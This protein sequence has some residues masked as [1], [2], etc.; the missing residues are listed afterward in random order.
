MNPTYTL[1]AG[2]RRANR[3]ATVAVTGAV[4]LALIPLVWLLVTVVSRGF[5]RLDAQFFTWS[6]R[7]VVGEGGGA[8][9]AIVGTVLITAATTAICVPI[10]VGTAIYLVEYGRGW[11]PRVIRFVVVVLTG[12]PSIVAGLFV[13]AVI[14]AICGPGTRSG[15]AGAAALSLLMIP[16]VITSS[17]EILALVPNRLREAAIGLGATKHRIITTVI[18][19]HALSGIVAAVMLGV[20]RI[21]GE[22]APLLLVAGFADSMNTDL[23]SGRMSTLPV[24]IYSQWQNKGANLAA[25][26]NRAWT[27]ALV[28]I[29]L[30]LIFAVASRLIVRLTSSRPQR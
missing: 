19:P 22:T 25:Y 15:L 20:C 7:G 5:A 21:I 2:R 14:M 3:L 26:D 27:A 11:L 18:W 28:L 4:F 13:Y 6:M 9:H 16:V 23:T 12:L 24:Y 30:V 10:G 17:E 8:I 1:S 29:G